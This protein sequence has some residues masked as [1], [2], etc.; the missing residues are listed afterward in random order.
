M[1]FPEDV[2]RLT[3]GGVTL[4]AA[5]PEDAPGVLEQCADPLSQQWTTVPLEYSAADA[6]SY[7]TEAMPEGWRS[8]RAWSFVIVARG[9][10]GAWR[11]GGNLALRNHGEGRAEVAYGAHPWARGRG[12]MEEA[13][14]LLVGWGFAE[15][16]LQTVIWWANQGNWAS[17]KLAWRV[18]FRFEGAPRQWLPQRGALRDAWVGTLLAG[19]DPFPRTP[20]YAVPVLTGR[21]VVLRE[22]RPSDADRVVEA[23]T[24]PETRRW[25]GTLPWPYGREQAEHYLGT[26][27]EQHAS[28]TAVNWAI[29]D[30]ADDSLIG[31]INLFDIREGVDAEVGYWVHPA[32]RGRGV[33]SEACRLALRHAFVPV[34]DGGLGLGRVRGVAAEGNHGSRKVL[35]RAGL[36]LQGRERQSIVVGGGALADAAI[37]DVLAAELGADAVALTAR[38]APR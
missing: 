25:L 11:Y 12:V 2:P 17:R 19:D 34:G 27:A 31:S 15:K 13:V 22:H 37:Y 29:A 24:D 26:R 21:Q 10:D 18:G 5:R 7:L 23:C 4:R 1:R 3:R 14:R 9:D 16:G 30:P 38:R 8:D 33:G 20:W 36:T 35:T 28:G 6:S 32:A